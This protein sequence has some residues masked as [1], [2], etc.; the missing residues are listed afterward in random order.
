MVR[1][2]FKEGP[3][4]LTSFWWILIFP[5]IQLE[6]ILPYSCKGRVLLLVHATAKEVKLLLLFVG[7]KGAILM[8]DVYRQG[9]RFQ[10]P[11]KASII[12]PKSH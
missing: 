8:H 9:L 4:S 12:N 2:V 10:L 11:L 7:K 5:K 1:K 3:N 6:I